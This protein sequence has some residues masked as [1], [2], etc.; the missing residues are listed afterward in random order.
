MLKAGVISDEELLHE[1]SLTA[2]TEL[3]HLNKIKSK[4]SS[5]PVSAISDKIVLDVSKE[6]N[7][8]KKDNVL[9]AEISKL[10]AQV[11]EL[12]S[13]RDEIKEMKK[14]LANVHHFEYPKSEFDSRRRHRRIFKCRS[15]EEK[16]HNFCNHCFSCG[17]S[18][19]RKKDC[20]K[21][22]NE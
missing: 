2:S 16:N 17:D 11:S 6:K 21:S 14:Q 3:E 19:H 7:K 8:N 13:V 22:K 18:D 9:L 4:V 5:N 20:K 12:S 15:C 10:S 1:I